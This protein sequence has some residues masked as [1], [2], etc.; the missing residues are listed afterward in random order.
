MMGQQPKGK[1][2]YYQSR[3]CVVG[4]GQIQVPGALEQWEWR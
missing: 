4:G 2:G 1:K 3:L